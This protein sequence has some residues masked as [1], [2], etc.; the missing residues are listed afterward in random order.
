MSNPLADWLLALQRGIVVGENNI[1]RIPLEVSAQMTERQLEL[2]AEA[3]SKK[4]ADLTDDE[5]DPRE[6]HR[7]WARQ[8][9]IPD[10]W[11]QIIWERKV[12]ASDQ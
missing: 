6:Y 12:A 4:D 3:L 11:E 9:K 5:P 1:C 8:N 2:L 7:E 10:W